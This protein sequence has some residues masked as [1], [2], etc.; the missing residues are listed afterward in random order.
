MSSNIISITRQRSQDGSCVIHTTWFTDLVEAG[1]LAT[2]CHTTSLL[3]TY[4]CGL[5]LSIGITEMFLNSFTHL[6]HGLREKEPSLSEQVTPLV[7]FPR[8][9]KKPCYIM[10]C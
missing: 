4:S 3:M 6:S 8:I 10:L 2:L 7:A 1:V 5:N 9:R